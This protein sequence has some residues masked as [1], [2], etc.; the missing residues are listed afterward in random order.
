[1]ESPAQRRLHAIQ[2]HLLPASD[3]P[4]SLVQANLTA[5]EFVH[6]TFSLYV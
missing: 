2:C 5:G 1:M 4:Q 6:G 3:D